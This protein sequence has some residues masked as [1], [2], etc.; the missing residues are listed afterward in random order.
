ML[1]SMSI[2]ADESGDVEK[3]LQEKIERM[4]SV[5]ESLSENL[6]NYIEVL[7]KKKQQ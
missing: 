5:I 1:K 4:R 6:E 3:L 7:S 2:Q